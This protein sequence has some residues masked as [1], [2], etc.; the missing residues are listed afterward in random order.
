MTQSVKDARIGDSRAMTVVYRRR[1]RYP[2]ACRGILH[3]HLDQGKCLHQATRT[4]IAA[5]RQQAL[6]VQPAESDRIAARR[7]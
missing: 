5:Q 4:L 7:P 2:N 1:Y 6:Q 3:R